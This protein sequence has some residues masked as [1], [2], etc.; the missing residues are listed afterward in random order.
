MCWVPKK[1]QKNKTTFS[2]QVLGEGV[3]D[4]NVPLFV[5]T[6]IT[7][8]FQFISDQNSEVNVFFWTISGPTLQ[9]L[10]KRFETYQKKSPKIFCARVKKQ[11]PRASG[12]ACAQKKVSKSSAQKCFFCK[13]DNKIRVKKDPPGSDQTLAIQTVDPRP[14]DL[15]VTTLFWVYGSTSLWVYGYRFQ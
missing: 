3:L 5:F 10:A 2:Q 15:L 8:I 13:T 1:F 9:C 7:A 14:Q 6:Q 12:R 11:I 4:K